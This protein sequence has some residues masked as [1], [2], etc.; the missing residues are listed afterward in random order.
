MPNVVRVDFIRDLKAKLRPRPRPLAAL[1]LA[2]PPPHPPAPLQ[3]PVPPGGHV[4]LAGGIPPQLG[5]QNAQAG[6]VNHPV[7]ALPALQNAIHQVGIPLHQL[8]PPPP[9]QPQQLLQQPA[10][11]PP[12]AIP[13]HLPAVGVGPLT[14]ELRT[15]CFTI[16]VA[17]D[18]NK[19]PHDPDKPSFQ[20]PHHERRAATD[21]K[22]NEEMRLVLHGLKLAAQH[23]YLPDGFFYHSPADCKTTA[24]PLQKHHS[25]LAARLHYG[26]LTA[27]EDLFE[28]V[29]P[30]VALKIHFAHAT[31]PVKADFVM[32]RE[33][34]K[35]VSPTYSFV[36]TLTEDGS[37]VRGDGR[38]RSTLDLSF[39]IDLCRHVSSVAR[40]LLEI[41]KGSRRTG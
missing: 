15:L 26:R 18:I 8:V 19:D 34:F 13:A 14:T 1:P 25:D 36:A 2:P 41:R 21:L 6:V 16:V 5:P 4:A 33:E 31:K 11:P 20:F 3:A 37:T 28:A 9:Q 29:P 22:D 40:E 39:S 12:Q 17:T 10:I 35:P 24:C 38:A 27:A 23:Q 7:L 32:V 30:N